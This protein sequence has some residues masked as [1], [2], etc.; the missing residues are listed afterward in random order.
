MSFK[1]PRNSWESDPIFGTIMLVVM[2]AIIPIPL[3]VSAMF[4]RT[5]GPYV[6]IILCL[7]FWAFEIWMAFS[8]FD[9]RRRSLSDDR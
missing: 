4:G 5:F 8:P 1:N 7:F 2:S 9:R 3:V 6:W